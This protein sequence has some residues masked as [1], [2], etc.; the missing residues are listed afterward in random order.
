MIS[1]AA[2]SR[3][4][5]RAEE[6]LRQRE[7]QIYRRID[8]MFAVLMMVQWL[9]AVA[10]AL[11]V[12]PRTWSGATSEV[13]PHVWYAFWAGGALASLPVWLAWRRPGD[14]ITRYTI[15]VAQMLFSSLLVQV[16]GGRLETHFHVFGSLAFLAAYRDW[17]VLMVATALVSA[18]Q[19]I[20][21]IFWPL[22]MF[23]VATADHWRWIEHT[24]WV[25][26]EDL[27]LLITMR[28]STEEMRNN[29]LQTALFESH[30]ADLHRYSEQ[31]HRS[32]EKERSIIEGSLDA[33]VE[34]DARGKVLNW[35]GPAE[36][37]FGWTVAEAIGS[38]L[39]E[40]VI[41]E[42]DQQRYLAGLRQL[43]ESPAGS[44]VHQRFEM[45]CVARG[46]R[47]FA[48]ELAIVSIQGSEETT[49]CA[50]VRDITDRKSHELDMRRAMEESEAANRT[51]SEFLANMSHEI[52]TPLNSILGFAELL[53]RNADEGDE[54]TRRDYADTI[55][56][57]A[58]HLME[59]INNVLD[60]S[61]I[62]AGKMQVERAR[63][64]PHQ[65]IAEVVSL[66]RVRAIE[67][68]IVLNYRWDGPIPETVTTDPHRVRQLLINLVGN[69]IKFTEQ[70]SVMIVAGVARE[71]DR[72]LLTLEVR[73]TGIGI[74]PSKLSDIFH[75]FVQADSSMTRRYGGTGLGL[76]ICKNIA[77][78]LGGDLSVDSQLG[79]GTTFT[80]KLEIG[81]LRHVRMFEAPPDAATGDYVDRPISANLQGVRVLL[82][83]DGETNRK[84]IQ[85]FLSRHGAEV[86][87]VENGEMACRIALAEQFDVV[88]MD[89][90][91]P[92]MDGYAATRKLRSLGFLKPIIALTAHAMKGDREKCTF[93]GCSG[94]LSKPVNVDE[95][96][97][98][99]EVAAGLELRHDELVKQEKEKKIKRALAGPI[100]S[101]LPTEDEMLR[102]I[103][104]EFVESIPARL[105]AMER[106]LA[107]EDYEELQRHVHG[108]KGSGG[109]A[110][111]TCLSEVSA[112]LES[113]AA[114]RKGDQAAALLGEL[115]EMEPLIVV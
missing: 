16:S 72:G 92:Q 65:V 108:L 77:A 44:Q 66:L 28:K 5:L 34:L 22:S 80:A 18:D 109:T 19:L 91:M 10:T 6:I 8:R 4:Q 38:Q 105:D 30:H 76:A 90:Q 27:F 50:F 64:S 29:A 99:V 9:G 20:R 33:V 114:A 39:E 102:E 62:E 111:F 13:H 88:L 107:D 25:L 73:D 98:A 48:V 110:G 58:R 75:P 104:A 113:Y 57:S 55:R 63:F 81:D 43:T 89:M 60:L 82:A 94:Y 97:R 32:F 40:L 79:R 31:L 69:A 2:D 3:Q 24:G 17:G 47:Q 53:V 83:D 12:S 56:T 112:E 46:G 103:V 23:G 95:L 37:L 59:L 70:G 68:G 74:E 14:T 115:R 61:K 45:E 54:R 85:V 87:T 11:C 96:I 78:A 52:R 26:F 106:A 71:G 36:R 41:P 15:A 84:L 21:G 86:Q 67:K 7:R 1:A 42:H 93:A 35:N 100:R 51:K 49:F 101:S